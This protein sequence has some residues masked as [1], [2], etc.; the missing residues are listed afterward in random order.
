MALAWAAAVRFV[1]IVLI[2]ALHCV[3][4]C[5]AVRCGDTKQALAAEEEAR[6]AAKAEALTRKV[7][8][9]REAQRAQQQRAQEQQAERQRQQE[10]ER[11]AAEE[12]AA[13][14]SVTTTAAAAASAGAGGGQSGQF[15]MNASEPDSYDYDAAAA[16]RSEYQTAA[17]AAQDSTAAAPAAAPAASGGGG[18]SSA[19]A[20]L[21]PEGGL[22]WT[23]VGDPAYGEAQPA[24]DHD[25]CAQY[26]VQWDVFRDNNPQLMVFYEGL[27]NWTPWSQ[28]RHSLGL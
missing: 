18:S 1:L 13:A 28:L 23:V 6:R 24:L 10:A 2:V 11:A 4:G 9:D 19:S 3:V 7:R 26:A 20:A 17:A 12:A 15:S 14:I 5:C 16:R 22:Y 21:F 25:T 27:P 8:Q